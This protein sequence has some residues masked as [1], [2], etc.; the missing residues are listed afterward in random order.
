MLLLFHP[1]RDEK[2]LL[3]GFTTIVS[4]QTSRARSPE[5]S[6]VN[7]KSDLVYQAYSKFNETLINNQDSHSQIKN[8]ETAGA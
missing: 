3:L 6:P 1:F 5:R 8:D 7:I 4:K 2:E